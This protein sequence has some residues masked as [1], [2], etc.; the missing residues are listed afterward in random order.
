MAGIF[1]SVVVD[2]IRFPMHAD[3]VHDELNYAC[4]CIAWLNWVLNL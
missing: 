1:F 3:A 4:N 2:W